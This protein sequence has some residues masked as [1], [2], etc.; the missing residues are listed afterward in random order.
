[1]EAP[2]VGE[3]TGELDGVVEAIG[4]GWE[5]E[6]G[7]GDEEFSGG[8]SG[9]MSLRG[10]SEHIRLFLPFFSTIQ[11]PANTSI[12]DPRSAWEKKICLFLAR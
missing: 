8:P 11:L 3:V 2:E 7:S 5:V 10:T 4:E 1:M 12:G 6:L 9:E